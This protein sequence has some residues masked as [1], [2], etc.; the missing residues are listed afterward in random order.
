LVPKWGPRSPTRLPETEKAEASSRVVAN[1]EVTEDDGDEEFASPTER[2]Y[3]VQGGAF[4][5][6][7]EPRVQRGG[8]R[9]GLTS[10][11]PSAN[12]QTWAMAMRGPDEMAVV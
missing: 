3:D 2:L 4:G 12:I 7:C 11:I 8:A 9:E 6:A 5:G 1:S 10:M